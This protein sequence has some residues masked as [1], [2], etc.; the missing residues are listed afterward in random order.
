MTQ[1]IS[2]PS[3]D[4]L[5]VTLWVAGALIGSVF[6]VAALAIAPMA[7]VPE[8]VALL[9]LARPRPR[10][11]G[12]AGALVGHGVVWLGLLVTSSRICQLDATDRCIYSLPFGPA[13][14]ADGP[15]WM[16]D[17]TRWIVGALLLFLVGIVLTAA[18]MRR[19]RTNERLAPADGPIGRALRRL[20]YHPAGPTVLAVA[21]AL[22]SWPFVAL[23]IHVYELTGLADGSEPLPSTDPA[24]WTAAAS[25]VLV[26]A[27]VAGFVGGWL[28]RHRRDSSYWVALLVAWICGIGGTTLLPAL[29]GQHFGTVPICIDGCAYSITTDNPGPNFLG[30]ALLFWL[31]PL[32]E[33]Q[34]L[35]ALIVGFVGWSQNSPPIRS[36]CTSARGAPVGARA[37]G[38]AA[39]VRARSCVR[40]P[41]DT[42]T[43]QWKPQSRP[44]AVTRQPSRNLVEEAECRATHETRF[45]AGDG[46]RTR[47]IEPA[48]LGLEGVSSYRAFVQGIRRWFSQPIDGGRRCSGSPVSI[49]IRTGLPVRG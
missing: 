27:V 47:D 49:H 25:A 8:L 41:S 1:E 9:V 22:T 39:T 29:L 17:T 3:L 14:S 32:Y 23:N 35:G 6:G 10:P 4:R 38:L 13:H 12:L 34:A 26:S 43:Q 33:G 18:A 30:A 5:G 24:R 31:G 28:I 42:A 21:L 46:S 44:S 19:L 36:A 40:N 16:A 15:A 37:A 48:G 45:G 20:S 11:F 2:S 7:I